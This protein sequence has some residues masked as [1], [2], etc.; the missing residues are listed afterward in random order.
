MIFWVH[1]RTGATATAGNKL[2]FIWYCPGDHQSTSLWQKWELEFQDFSIPNRYREKSSPESRVQPGIVLEMKST[3]LWNRL[4]FIH[5]MMNTIEEFVFNITIWWAN[6]YSGKKFINLTP[7]TRNQRGD[8]C[9][10]IAFKSWMIIFSMIFHCNWLGSNYKEK[11]VQWLG[12][13]RPQWL[14]YLQNSN[15]CVKPS[16]SFSKIK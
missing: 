4:F 14:N 15:H 9:F 1:C 2:L 5:F 7:I 3:E 13:C 10:S 6:S 11:E 16:A 12:L 8:K